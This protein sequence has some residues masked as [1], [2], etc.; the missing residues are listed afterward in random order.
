MSDVPSSPTPPAAPPAEPPA[1]PNAEEP[2]A[3]DP[4]A[5]GSPAPAPPP[6]VAPASDLPNTALLI[7]KDKV[8]RYLTD[9]AG[10]IQLLPDGLFAVDSG[11][12]RVLVLCDEWAG[13]D[14][15]LVHVFAPLLQ[16]VKPSPELYEHVALHAD[17]YLFGHLSARPEDDGT[18]AV[19][20]THVMLG[21]YLDPE[22]LKHA[23]GGVLAPADILDD[24]LQAR[25]GGKRF[26]EDS[27]S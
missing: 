16:G 12:A 21:D 26:H 6:A 4:A 8:Q 20:F 11:S 18:I 23:V 22:E 10:T 17:D 2:P 13:A 19:M 25:F 15:T 27:P 5:S 24:E 9:L 14:Q 3:S 1:P 7:L